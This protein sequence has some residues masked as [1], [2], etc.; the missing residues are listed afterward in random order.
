V[1][2]DLSQSEAV[3][4]TRE[5]AGLRLTFGGLRTAPGAPGAPG[6]TLPGSEVV[7]RL[8]LRGDAPEVVVEV[9]ALRVDP[10]CWR[11]V[12]AQYPARLG[13]LHSYVE[14]GYLVLPHWEGAL[15]PTSR[16]TLPPVALWEFEDTTRTAQAM[17]DL[18]VPTMPWFGAAL[19]RAGRAGFLCLVE[20]AADL[21]LQVIANYALQH[22]YDPRGVVSPLMRLAACS[23]VW[24]AS[25]GELGYPRRARYSFGPG[26][27]Y[28][29]MAKRYRAHARATGEFVSLQ[30][31]QAARPAIERLRGAPYLALYA[32]YPHYAPG[33]HPAYAGYTYAQV[34]DVVR[35][36]A[37]RLHLPAAFVH[38]WG[39]FTK[40]PPLALPFDTAP[41]PVDALRR[42]VQSAHDA[43]YL[44]ALYN[45][46]TALLE[47]TPHWNGDLVYQEASGG[48]MVGR[49]WNRVCA[50]HHLE[51][52]RQVMP[53]IKAALGVQATYVDC[54]NVFWRECYAREHPATRDEDRQRRLAL[55]RYLQ[56]LGLIFGGEHVQSWAVPAVDYCNGVGTP[57]A[58]PRLLSKFPVP[59]WQLVFHDAVAGYGHAADDYTRTA[60]RDFADKLLRDLALGVPPIYF[61]NLHDYP[62]WRSRIALAHRAT[63]DVL[64][65]IGFDEL[66]SHEYLGGDWQVQRT[67]FASGAEITINLALEPRDSG[68]ARLPAKGFRV[69]G[70]PGGPRTGRF[71][72]DFFA[73]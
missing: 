72:L 19:E 33:V 45:D 70:L 64:R 11:L 65:Q 21:Q 53:Q 68:E 44:F 20:T 35:D 63:G 43:G 18:A 56:R 6:A 48:K 69:T 58:A 15:V 42:A 38:L 34:H 22:A 2:C 51:L 25:R 50:A 32:G 24:L 1:T 26:L 3:A 49:P 10:Q 54:V 36:L 57:P 61:L 27:D 12:S 14:P 47:E 55:M 71:A 73:S 23:P 67:R 4:V 41:G 46:F 5:G 8:A 40:Q 52:A 39:G 37:E 31:K 30:D 59:L 16:V 28:V 17:N 66:L 62:Q 9:E 60:G 7:T 29:A 13:A